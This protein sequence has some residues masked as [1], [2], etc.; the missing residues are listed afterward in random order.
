MH[1]AYDDLNEREDGFDINRE[2]QQQ[3]NG[4]GTLLAAGKSS[5]VPPSNLVARSGSTEPRQSSLHSFTAKAAPPR[6]QLI[7]SAKMQ[8]IGS[9]M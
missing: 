8:L 1:S 6:T 9:K 3:L 4:G 2:M 7:S 5:G